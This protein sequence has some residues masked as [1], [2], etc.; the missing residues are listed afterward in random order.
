MSETAGTGSE[1]CTVLQH[2]REAFVGCRTIGFTRF[3]RDPPTRVLQRWCAV[4]RGLQR[5]ACAAPLFLGPMPSSEM[6]FREIVLHNWLYAKIK[7]PNWAVFAALKSE[8]GK[9]ALLGHHCLQ[10]SGL[11]GRLVSNR[12]TPARCNGTSSGEDIR[13]MTVISASFTW[14]RIVFT[15]LVSLA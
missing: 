8:D 3:P 7:N 1:Y 11:R 10:R 5:E 9:L 15:R 12:A 4:S 13:T 2:T 14:I 6:L